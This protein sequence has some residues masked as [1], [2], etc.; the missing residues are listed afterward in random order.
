M[1]D[2]DLWRPRV[3]ELARCQEAG[4]VADFWLRDGHALG[5]SA[6]PVARPDRRG[7]ALCQA[8]GLHGQLDRQVA[9]ASVVHHAHPPPHV[10]PAVRQR[11]TNPRT[12][13]ESGVLQQRGSDPVAQ[14]VRDHLVA[15]R[16][17][18]LVTDLVRPHRRADRL[19][20]QA[21][22]EPRLVFR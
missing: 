16:L 4:R 15:V 1:P 18:G 17:E 7:E 6:S 5:L 9:R 3:A 13:G 19:P 14:G 22:A 11:A 8:L 12:S 10:A 2:A 20:D 21:D